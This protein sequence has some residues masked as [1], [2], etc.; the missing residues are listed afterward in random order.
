VERR[1]IAG[2]ELAV[3]VGV[4][5]IAA[6]M[7]WQ[8]SEIP[9]AQAYARV[10]PRVIPYAVAFGL[11][12]LG[13]LLCLDAWR[14]GWVHEAEDEPGAIDWRAFGWLGLGLLLNVA[15]IAWLGFIIASA[16]MFVCVAR[17]FGSVQWKR[18]LVVAVLICLVAYLGFDKLLGINIGAGILEG[19]L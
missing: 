7:A 11:F 14:G 9:V 2:W 13:V 12:V 15:L 4:V 17:A 1:S 19:I 8:T 5:V 16:M 18:D 10:G 3:G 6:A